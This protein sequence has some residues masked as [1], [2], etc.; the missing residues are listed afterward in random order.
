VLALLGTTVGAIA[1]AL[2]AI[3]LF[4]VTA[5]VIGQRRHEVSVR[6]ALGATQPAIL[7]M[8]VRE[9]LRPVFIGLGTGLMLAL[10]GTHIL[11]AVLSGIGARDPIAIAAAVL[12]LLGCALAAVAVPARRAARVSPSETLKQG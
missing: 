4:G 12:V 10:L 5:F 6:L 1:L 7:R 11:Q 3:G 9:S 8:L 2:T